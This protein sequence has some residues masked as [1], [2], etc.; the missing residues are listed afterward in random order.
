MRVQQI[1]K[2]PT[3][4]L[5]LIL[6]FNYVYNDSIALIDLRV[7]AYFINNHFIKLKSFIL[8]VKKI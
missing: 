2:M 5:N 4:D 7:L 3:I 8:Q 6:I 1:N